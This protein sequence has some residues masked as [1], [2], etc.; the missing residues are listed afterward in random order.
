MGVLP[1]YLPVGT[2]FV[3]EGHPGADGGLSVSSRYLIVPGSGRIDLRGRLAQVR[4]G[5]RRV[6]AANRQ[7]RSGTRKKNSSGAPKKFV[8]VTGTAA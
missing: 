8:V 2:V 3:V 1:K 4:R 5:S 6:S 7:H